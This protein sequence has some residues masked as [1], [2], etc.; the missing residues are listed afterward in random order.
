MSATGDIHGVYPLRTLHQ[1]DAQSQSPASIISKPV[2]RRLYT[3]PQVMLW[4]AADQQAPPD[5]LADISQSGYE[6]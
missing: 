4:K 5:Q 2:H 6:I 1:E 3:D